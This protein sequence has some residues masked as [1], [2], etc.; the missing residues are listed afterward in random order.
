MHEITDDP[1]VVA[2]KAESLRSL[3]GQVAYALGK[4]MIHLDVPI[5]EVSVCFHGPLMRLDVAR[6]DLDGAHLKEF[7]CGFNAN[8]ADPAFAS[9]LELP[10]A[11]TLQ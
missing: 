7:I 5:E 11:G 9:P 8:P 3:L 2:I 10:G 4:L 1:L 6:L